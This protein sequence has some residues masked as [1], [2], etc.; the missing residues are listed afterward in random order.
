[1]LQQ[2]QRPQA[3]DR[4]RSLER[5]PNL[6]AVGPVFANE[7]VA[8]RRE[9]GLARRELLAMRRENARLL[10]ALQAR[11]RPGPAA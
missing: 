1:M 3:G 2:A 10:R 6:R 5:L 4:E 7:L 9:L 8:T 11:G